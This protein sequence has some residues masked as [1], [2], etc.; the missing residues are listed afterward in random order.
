MISRRNAV[1]V[2][3]GGISFVKN[4]AYAQPAVIAAPLGLRW[5]ASAED[6][7]RDAA[8]LKEFQNKEYGISFVATKMSKSL[9]DQ[10][11]TLLS[12]GLNDKLWRIVITSRDYNNDPGGNAV[13]ARYA[14]LSESLKEKYG[15]P[16]AVHRLGD[17]IYA[18][19]RYFLSGIRG[20]E[21]K[22]YSNFKTPDLRIQL[23]VTA[24][25]SST[26]GWRLIYE[27]MPLSKEFEASK[28]NRE[29]EKL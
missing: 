4:T 21:S 29:K 23:G 17:S 8:D 28:K 12:F 11:A 3:V 14:E 13:V 15:K 5:G 2:I 22:W 1:C 10:D 20:G 25:D 24:T 26:G 27:Y 16:S 19:P 6:I 9:A 7:K 18:E